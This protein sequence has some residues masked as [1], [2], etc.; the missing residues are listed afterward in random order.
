MSEPEP[1]F[2]VTRGVPTDEE[3]A[4][5][6]GAILLRRRPPTTSQTRRGPR[7]PAAQGPAV[8]ATVGG[9][10]WLPADI[11]PSAIRRLGRSVARSSSRRSSFLPDRSS[12]VVA[13]S[14]FR[15]SPFLAGRS[16]IK[17]FTGVEIRAH[18]LISSVGGRKPFRH[19]VGRAD[20]PTSG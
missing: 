10:R 2:R 12:R 15:R 19:F 13:R 7:G 11:P 20:G 5:L 1:F 9:G 14:S 17:E 6:V 18:R 3:L 8:A 4:A 16:S